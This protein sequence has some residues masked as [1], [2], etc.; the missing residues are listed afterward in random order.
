MQTGDWEIS[1]R[2]CA[3]RENDL[4]LKMTVEMDDDKKIYHLEKNST[5]GMVHF[6]GGERQVAYEKGDDWDNDWDIFIKEVV[7]KITVKVNSS[8]SKIVRESWHEMI[9]WPEK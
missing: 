2:M 7:E 6:L 1:F 3:E 8:R 4:M 5:V 9:M